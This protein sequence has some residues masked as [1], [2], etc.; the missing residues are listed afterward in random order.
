MRSLVLSMLV[1]SGCGTRECKPGTV[2]LQLRFIDGAEAADTLDFSVSI[3]GGAPRSH[4]VARKAGGS[5]DTVALA[6]SDGYPRGK[7][8]ALMVVASIGGTMLASSSTDFTAGA[9]CDVESL[10]LD[11]AAPQ[12]GDLARGDQAA[13]EDLGQSDSSQPQPDLFTPCQPT[14]ACTGLCGSVFDGCG[15][16]NCG[17]CQITSVGPGIANAGDTL[18]LNGS[19]GQSATVTFPSASPQPATVLG[20]QRAVVKVPAGAGTGDLMVSTGGQSFGPFPFRGP[21]FAL[22]LQQFNGHYEQADQLRAMPTLTELTYGIGAVRVGRYIYMLGGPGDTTVV[23]AL[24]NAD[25]TLSNFRAAPSGGLQHA[26]MGACV[27]RLGGFVYAIGGRDG[28]SV[29]QPTVERAAIGGDDTLTSFADV[30]AVNLVTARRTFTCDVIGNW[31][32]VVGGYNSGTD[33]PSVERASIAA[34]GTLGSF[35]TVVGVTLVTARG[36]HA[37]VVTKSGLY[38]L[39]GASLSNPVASTERVAIA[40]DG[41]LSGSFAAVTGLDMPTPRY[42][43]TA[44]VAG[45]TAYVVGGHDATGESNLVDNLAID[46]AGVISAFGSPT[47][48][49]GRRH[50]HAAFLAGDFLYVAGGVDGSG[51]IKSLQRASLNASGGIAAPDIAPGVS[52]TPRSIFGSVVS[53]NKIYLSG[54]YDSGN[55]VLQSIDSATIGADGTL[56]NFSDAGISTVPLRAG[57][58]LVAVGPYVYAIGGHDGSKYLASTDRSP[59]ADDGTLGDFGA[60]GSVLVNARYGFTT[61]VVGNIVYVCGGKGGDS[62]D[63]TCES[64]SFDSAGNLGNFANY[65]LSVLTTRVGVVWQNRAYFFGDSGEQYSIDSNNLLADVQS[66]NGPADLRPMASVVGNTVWFLGGAGPVPYV[67]HMALNSDGSVG[68]LQSQAFNLK[69]SRQQGTV[70]TLSDWLYVVGG[71]GIGASNYTVERAALQ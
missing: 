69:G 34:D 53:G 42:A 51:A 18:I 71:I 56:S 20:P 35:S 6:F 61:A 36:N 57:H 32:Y 58:A 59:V 7:H 39:G 4:Q 66:V 26:R 25:G 15:T 45:H 1:L 55:S 16:I 43:L 31:L 21:S 23:R 60:G 47:S 48:L 67:H 64:A 12:N 3:D 70:A 40:G 8:I 44:T 2:Y 37:S 38:V 30:A 49:A 29:D 22:G 65:T 11:G 17:P 24:V 14:I 41:S 5:S 13:P 10:T 50:Q 52:P 9:S 68:S 54:G 46:D 28:S 62:T 33:L 19:F 63:T 27:I